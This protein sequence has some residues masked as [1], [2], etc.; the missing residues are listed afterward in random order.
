M[1]VVNCTTAAGEIAPEKLIPP[2]VEGGRP[3]PGHVV[4][5]RQEVHERT[6]ITFLDGVKYRTSAISTYLECLKRLDVHSLVPFVDISRSQYDS[7][8][9]ISLYKFFAEIDSR[10]IAYGLTMTK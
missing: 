5:A 6:T 10:Y 4:Q 7:R 3:E 9:R 8:I 1:I 2:E